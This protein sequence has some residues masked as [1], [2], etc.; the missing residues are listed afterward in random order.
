M[1]KILWLIILTMLMI[2]P[3]IAQA[4]DNQV[5]T[6]ET[7]TDQTGTKA[8]AYFF[9]G[10]GCPHCAAMEPFLEQLSQEY[11]FTIEKHEVYFDKEGRALFEKMAK[12]FGKQVQ[13][14][15]TLFINGKMIV[16]YSDSL[17]KTI[18]QEVEYCSQH[19]CPSPAD[20]LNPE[21]DV[22]ELG[23]E[24]SGSEA[25]SE[26]GSDKGTD[27]QSQ[28]QTD[29]KKSLTI[30]AVLGAAAVDAINPC[31]FAVLIVLMTTVLV[32]KD[33]KRALFAGIAF[34]TAIYLSYFLM[35]L[36]LYSAVQAAGATHWF[37]F[38][39][40]GLAIVIG[41]FN[42]KDYFWYG[43]WF[44]ME[45]PLRWRPTLRRLIKGVTSIPGAFLVGLLVSLFLLPC[46]SGPYIVILG[47]LAETTTRDYAIALLLL[48]NLVFITPMI[49]ITCAVSCGFTTTHKAE[50]WRQR[51]LKM[52]HLI[53][54]MILIILGI[55]MFAAL[56]SG[57]I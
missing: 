54:G 20:K 8:Q 51:K 16:G 46:T 26:T 53:A 33:K 55:A 56:G 38:L 4:Q 50:E 25:Q 57:A 28:R 11:N 35:G 23:V 36:G 12:A 52:L 43:K 18:R 47:L 6:D 41:L 10:Q 30:P 27:M 15:P 32:T 3:A 31:A 21:N 1:K 44:I 42:L 19:Q 2:L 45:V 39:V 17:A 13:G 29:M 40:A 5:T 7:I 22:V 14:V 34:T 48:Y 37:Y 24:E 49:I 9:Y